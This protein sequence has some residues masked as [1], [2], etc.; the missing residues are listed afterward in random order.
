VKLKKGKEKKLPLVQS[1]FKIPI[2][3]T[4]Y[5]L[6]PPMSRTMKIYDSVDD[7]MDSRREAQEQAELAKHWAE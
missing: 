2:T 3:N 4:V 1:N 6:V 5:L 7:A